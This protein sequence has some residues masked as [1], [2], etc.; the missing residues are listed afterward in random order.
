MSQS[1][2]AGLAGL[3]RS[4][5]SLIESGKKTPTVDVAE[6]IAEVLGCEVYFI[7]KDEL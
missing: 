5:V 2:L 7:L 6:R 3:S 1:K 4:Y